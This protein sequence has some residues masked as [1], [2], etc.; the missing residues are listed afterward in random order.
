MRVRAAAAALCALLAVAAVEGS[1]EHCP[2]QV[3]IVGLNAAARGSGIS[4]EDEGVTC[5]VDGQQIGAP[6]RRYG[7]VLSGFA[8]LNV[9]GRLSVRGAY[10]GGCTT[11]GPKAAPCRNELALA[12]DHGFVDTN[13]AAAVAWRGQPIVFFALFNRGP[14]SGTWQAEGFGLD[15]P[16]AGSSAIAMAD[17]SA[18]PAG[19]R[20]H[21]YL[22]SEEDSFSL[23]PDGLGAG[24]FGQVAIEPRSYTLYLIGDRQIGLDVAEVFVPAQITFEADVSFVFVISGSSGAGANDPLQVTITRIDQQRATTWKPAESFQPVPDSPQHQMCGWSSGLCERDEARM[25]LDLDV[26]GG[27][28]LAF[29]G[30][31][32]TCSESAQ[33]AA[34]C[35]SRTCHWDARGS[36]D[37]SPAAGVNEAFAQMADAL[38]GGDMPARIDHEESLCRAHDGSRG[39]CT[40]SGCI[41]AGDALGT[42]E[43]GPAP[44]QPKVSCTGSNTAA[45]VPWSEIHFKSDCTVLV[46]F[47]NEDG[48]KSDLVRLVEVGGI[49]VSSWLAIARDSCDEPAQHVFAEEFQSLLELVNPIEADG[50]TTE[51][52][53]CIDTD[54]GFECHIAQAV[55]SAEN[56]QTVV[57]QSD[58]IKYGTC[59][60]STVCAMHMCG[61][62]PDACLMDGYAILQDGIEVLAR[63][64]SSSVLAAANALKN[65]CSVNDAVACSQDNNCLWEASLNFCQLRQ[66]VYYAEAL[67]A[68]LETPIGWALMFWASRNDVCRSAYVPSSCGPKREMA[69]LTMQASVQEVTFPLDDLVD[70]YPIGMPIQPPGAARGDGTTDPRAQGSDSSE[71]GAQRHD[72]LSTYGRGGHQHK[73]NDAN[74]LDIWTVVIGACALSALVGVVIVGQDQSQKQKRSPLDE[75]LGVEMQSMPKKHAPAE[76]ASFDLGQYDAPDFDSPDSIASTVFD[77]DMSGASSGVEYSDEVSSPDEP[78][79]K[80]PAPRQHAFFDEADLFEPPA[81]QQDAP[82]VLSGCVPQLPLAGESLDLGEMDQL[83]SPHMS[84][85]T[86]AALS[87]TPPP[88]YDEAPGQALP[89]QMQMPVIAPLQP[90]MEQMQSQHLLQHAQQQMQQHQMQQQQMQQMQLHQQLQQ[91][92]FA[93]ARQMEPIAAQSSAQPSQWWGGGQPNMVDGMDHQ[94]GMAGPVTGAPP[95]YTDVESIGIQPVAGVGAAFRSMGSEPGQGA[96]SP[97][98]TTPTGARRR[99]DPHMKQ[100]LTGIMYLLT[101]SPQIPWL[102]EVDETDQEKL[103][104]PVE[105]MA[106]PFVVAV[107]YGRDSDAVKGHL[108]LAIAEIFAAANGTPSRPDKALKWDTL[109]RDIL[110]K[111]RKRCGNDSIYSYVDSDTG[112]C[113]RRQIEKYAAAVESRM[114]C[115]MDDV[116]RAIMAK[117]TATELGA[118]PMLHMAGDMM[119]SNAGL[120]GLDDMPMPMPIPIRATPASAPVRT[121]TPPTSAVDHPQVDSA[122]QSWLDSQSGS[123]DGSF[124]LP[125]MVQQLPAYST[126]AAEPQLLLLQQ[127]QQQQQQRFQQQQ[128]QQQHMPLKQPVRRPPHQ[129]AIQREPPRQSP[130]ATRAQDSAPAVAMFM[131]E[132]PVSSHRDY[133][134]N[135]VLTPDDTEE[136]WDAAGPSG[137]S[138]LD[139][140]AH[141]RT[142]GRGRAGG[143]GAGAGSGPGGGRGRGAAGRRCSPSDDAADA[144]G[145][146]AWDP[147]GMQDAALLAAPPQVK[148]G[149]SG[150]PRRSE[151]R[152]KQRRAPSSA[153]PAAGKKG[154][155]K[156][157]SAAATAAAAAAPAV[158]RAESK[159]RCPVVPKVEPVDDDADGAAGGASPKVTVEHGPNGEVRRYACTWPGCQYSSPSSGHLA[160]HVRVHTG[161]KPYRCDWQGCDYAAAQRGHLTAHRRKH[162]GERPFK[163]TFDGCDF[164]A[165]RS[166]HLTRHVKTKHGGGEDEDEDGDA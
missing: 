31:A 127:Q 117:V 138:T 151:S 42:A 66:S 108:A 100:D 10:A 92:L 23:T 143:G 22:V 7:D 9:T 158:A 156:A 112:D 24:E 50:D 80:H 27:R 81:H 88:A 8:C 134:P 75:Y 91:Q 28:A 30:T 148:S 77:D 20:W 133:A 76:S 159:K 11:A 65:S 18:R 12:Q 118:S 99:A 17:L 74:D 59:L 141:R 39:T 130:T 87:G 6:G 29:G 124:G 121:H 73:P 146:D 102:T 94:G 142:D 40:A 33:D 128:F 62:A 116:T 54:S 153:P 56:L 85:R 98:K 13:L 52:S 41:W 15:R 149:G 63:A 51:L 72:G 126:G 163:C 115:P 93:Q 58:E 137:S 70:M 49:E 47:V 57:L 5:A 113:D 3:Q 109:Q 36:C 114:E 155:G 21:L 46:K 132:P 161:E 110:W 162:T 157:K 166:W 90:N 43:A 147:T 38:T 144:G 103:R 1:G 129:A 165:S 120:G 145:V 78:D 136:S 101:H 119:S 106:P 135:G 45:R 48:T 4:V 95:Q 107:R 105:G 104:L 152:G 53:F 64:D 60:S 150:K 19:G 34:T 89:M 14:S 25:L 32:T 111:Y 37:F 35:V 140:S 2:N 79:S 131:T 26:A 55:N 164:A 96:V 84:P 125:P 61:V 16:A 97:N 44:P 68:A 154:N 82:P 123:I 160:R 83:P 122:Q 67:G 86:H 69:G 139:D 71:N